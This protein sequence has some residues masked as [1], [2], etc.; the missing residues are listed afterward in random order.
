[1]ISALLL[2]V[3]LTQSAGGIE[4]PANSPFTFREAGESSGSPMS[5]NG[6]IEL[7][8]E[9]SFEWNIVD[10]APE[11]LGLRIIPNE[12]DLSLLPY[13]KFS[14][15]TELDVVGAE[16]ISR[17]LLSESLVA[18]LLNARVLRVDGVASFKVGD[19]TTAVDC[20]HRWYSVKVLSVQNPKEVAQ[21][22]HIPERRGC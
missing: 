11:S 9:F 20:N 1:V 22:L 8:A 19:L 3:S 10:D 13:A 18:E 12:S 4:I 5:F 14:R 7:T 21:N 6:E 15:P 17:M 2:V 16:E